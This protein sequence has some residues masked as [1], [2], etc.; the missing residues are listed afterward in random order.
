M[1]IGPP[2]SGALYGQF[3]LRGP[4]IFG[5]GITVVDLIGRLLIIERKDALKWGI[6]TLAVADQEDTESQPKEAAKADGG[7]P[8]EGPEKVEPHTGGPSENPA[9]H[10]VGSEQANEIVDTPTLEVSA[11]DSAVEQQN[12]IEDPV[13]PA[14]Q[15]ATI[16]PTRLS[17]MG[18]V[19]TLGRAPRALAG[20]VN[21]LIF[22][23]VV[24][25]S[26]I[27]SSLLMCFLRSI[28]FTA[29]EPSMPLHLQSVW[30]LNATMV[31]VV[32]IGGVI[33]AICEYTCPAL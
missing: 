29:Q 26:S 32:M 13:P 10:S 16:A 30:G 15:A 28:A 27:C 24:S 14:S 2:V 11:A 20:M 31:G 23:C 3:G 21:T 19:L 4:Y 12:K 22:A 8:L 5:I 18:V 33:S 25:C 9:I 17:L 7:Q 6:D 1:L